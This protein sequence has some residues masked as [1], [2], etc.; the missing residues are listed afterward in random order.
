MEAMTCSAAGRPCRTAK[1]SHSVAAV[2][3]SKSASTSGDGEYHLITDSGYGIGSG[4]AAERSVS[5]SSSPSHFARTVRWPSGGGPAHTGVAV[6]V[7][8]SVAVYAAALSVPETAA[9]AVTGTAERVRACETV[10]TRSGVAVAAMRV[11]VALREGVAEGGSAGVG[12]RVRVDVAVGASVAEP[13]GAPVGLGD[14]VADR[15]ERAVGVW[16]TRSSEGDGERVREDVEASE[17][18]RVSEGEAVAVGDAVAVRRARDR[19]GVSVQVRGPGA[20]EVRESDAE[21][22][23]VT[24]GSA[25]GECDGAAVAALL[26]VGVLDPLG[27]E[28]VGQVVGVVVPVAL[29]VRAREVEGVAAGVSVAVQVQLSVA[30]AGRESVGVGV[31]EREREVCAV[32]VLKEPVGLG[33]R[34]AVR[35]GERLAVDV[36]SAVGLWEGDLDRV[37]L[38]IWEPD[39]VRV[40]ERDEAGLRVPVAVAVQ[41]ADAVPDGDARTAPDADLLGVAEPVRVREAASVGR[42]VRVG[43]GVRLR[44]AEAESVSWG[45]GEAVPVAVWLRVHDGDALV[46]GA[47]DSDAVHVKPRLREDVPERETVPTC[48]SEA[49]DRGLDVAEAAAVAVGVK[50]AESESEAGREGLWVGVSEQLG[51]VRVWFAVGVVDGVWVGETVKFAEGVVVGLAVRVTDTE[52]VVLPSPLSD[53][54]QLA[55]HVAERAEEAVGVRVRWADADTVKDDAVGRGDGEGVPV[56]VR[57]GESEAETVGERLHDPELREAV[58]DR[59]AVRRGVGDGVR[60]GVG[61]AEWGG[62]G[63]G[64]AGALA[65]A[66]PVAVAEGCAVAVAVADVTEGVALGGDAVRDAL[67]VAVALPEGV[68]GAVWVN[69]GEGLGERETLG[70]TR[71]ESDCDSESEGV[72]DGLEVAVGVGRAVQDADCVA[73]PLRLKV[74]VGA[75][76]RDCEGLPLREAVREHVHE[77][78]TETEPTAV[79]E[80]GEAVAERVGVAL[81]DAVAVPLVGVGVAVPDRDAP[82]AENVRV[83]AVVTVW[84]EVEDGDAE[85]LE[86]PGSVEVGVRRPLLVAVAVCDPEERERVAVVA[87]GDGGDAEGVGVVVRGKDA[88]T[89]CVAEGVSV[90][91]GDQGGVHVADRL[92]V[93]VAVADDGEA[94]GVADGVREREEEGLRV[95]VRLRETVGLCRAV[96]DVG[97]SEAGEGGAV[98]DRVCVREPLGYGEGVALRVH[99]AVSVSEADAD[100]LAEPGPEEVDVGERETVPP[101]DRLRVGDGVPEP[102]GRRVPEVP[103][104]VR[105]GGLRVR[106]AV[107]VVLPR[108]AVPVLV[109]DGERDAEGEA[110]AVAMREGVGD[111]DRGVVGDGERLRDAVAEADHEGVM[112]HVGVALGLGEHVAVGLALGDGETE[113]L[114]VRVAVRDGPGVDVPVRVPDPV[115]VTDRDG[116]AEAV[117]DALPVL[118]R[119][120]VADAVGLRPGVADAEPLRLPV[121]EAVRVG[122]K[123]SVEVGE[124][125]RGE[126]VAL[127]VSETVPVGV[128]EGVGDRVG[129]RVGEAVGLALRDRV[130][131][132]DAE[133]VCDAERV[134]ERRRVAVLVPLRVVEGEHAPVRLVVPLPLWEALGLAEG[135]GLRLRLGLGGEAVKVDVGATVQDELGEADAD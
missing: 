115:G 106:D 64:E 24:V 30:A 51:C 9:V 5:T 88:V 87:V 7:M 107:L 116:V 61:D 134:P 12:V 83:R 67:C 40:A 35:D 54:L 15:V 125:V 76:V 98:R 57:G 11:W 68:P 80:D 119:L 46:L 37:A 70:D 109:C 102:E 100:G 52:A 14:D 49:V 32:A 97:V 17:A 36:G 6:G 26:T 94:D 50:T 18:L 85:R 42:R 121:E 79:A 43:V 91:D 96:R 21:S 103:D 31:C 58:A 62:D 117:R 105:L 95:G 123:V 44:D 108:E 34:L 45:G 53:A 55:V 65:E 86:L 71:R 104:A 59:V 112:R 48:V 78:E 77:T 2:W 74:A 75:G 72:V 126:S 133:G 99:V 4:M 122:A 60:V 89:L 28:A 110:L 73:V 23:H 1:G 127:T 129:L 118:E 27:G 113:A 93:R 128:G 82:V 92:G 22:V 114:R 29:A 38:N 132:G 101:R 90:R 69:V 84:L 13:V 135:E 56:M 131:E 20:V 111:A 120:G 33:V 39:R 16:V 25:V 130:A 41:V 19:V 63:E 66:D 47:E 8:V 3:P 10:R 124:R 81:G